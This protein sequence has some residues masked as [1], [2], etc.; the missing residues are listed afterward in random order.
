MPGGM[1]TALTEML[2]HL[3]DAI[4]QFRTPAPPI[5]MDGFFAETLTALSAT[6]Q[7]ADV[8]LLPGR[9]PSLRVRASDRC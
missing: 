4:L 6:P 9:I 2:K 1:I 7:S 3:S 5:P 8:N